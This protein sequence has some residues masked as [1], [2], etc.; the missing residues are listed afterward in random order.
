M[1]KVNEIFSNLAFFNIIII[2]ILIKFKEFCTFFELFKLFYKF[3][4]QLNYK[5]I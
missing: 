2:K 3:L 1:F 4:T 5:K